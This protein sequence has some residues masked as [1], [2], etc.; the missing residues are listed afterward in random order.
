M[1]YTIS[2]LAVALIVLA[3]VTYKLI[4]RVQELD[5]RVR[6]GSDLQT[7]RL[8]S[9]VDQVNDKLEIIKEKHNSFV[10]YTTKE[11]GAVDE[12]KDT[13][14]GKIETL[15]EKHNRLVDFTTKGLEAVGEL[16]GTVKFEIPRLEAIQR[17]AENTERGV[18]AILNNRDVD[19]VK[20]VK[21]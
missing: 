6:N 8:Q 3:T 14:N 17:T 15:K 7:D 2:I 5:T 16:K 12:L 13:V 11:L 1:I 20:E 4:C 9:V 18:Y 10:D 21:P 19:N